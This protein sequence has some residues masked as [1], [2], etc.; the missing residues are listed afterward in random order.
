MTSLRSDLAVAARAL[1]RAPRFS[2]LSILVL[3]LGIGLNAMLFS[4]ADAVVFRPFPFA[5]A[6]RLVIAG[7]NLIAP[8]SEIAYRDFLAWRAQA[9]TFADMAAIGSSSWTWQLRTSGEPVTVR[10]RV[11]SGHFFELMG[12]SPLLGRTFRPDDDRPG[13]ARTIVLSHGFWQRQFGGD[14]GVIGRTIVLS[15]RSFTVVGV[16]PPAFRYPVGADVWTPVGPELAAI[17]SSIPN[18]PPDGGDVG[19]FF[20]V[21]RLNGGAVIGGGSS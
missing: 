2:A 5:D 16:M 11:V 10:Y 8:R 6:G 12:A 14:H 19:I 13:S 7:E 18:L 4:V 3:A 1:R 9:R 21:G 15:E 20:V 17:A